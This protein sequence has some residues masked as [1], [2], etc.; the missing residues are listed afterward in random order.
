MKHPFSFFAIVLIV[1]TLFF[2]TSAFQDQKSSQAEPARCCFHKAKDLV[3][4]DG[5]VEFVKKKAIVPV[6]KVPAEKWFILTDLHLER[7][8]RYHAYPSLIQRKDGKEVERINNVFL[9]RN[10][11]GTGPYSTPPLGNP[12]TGLAFPPQS[13]LMLSSIPQSDNPN[14]YAYHLR[15][16]LTDQ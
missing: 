8:G 1:A 16:Y 15:G 11:M 3:S 12:T 9:T 10:A 13:L 14:K 7:R 6:F 4:R 2:G 5:K